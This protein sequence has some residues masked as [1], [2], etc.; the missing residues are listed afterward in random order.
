LRWF[1]PK[2]EV[3]LCGHAMLATAP[4]LWEPGRLPR[5][6]AAFFE[7][8]SGLLTAEPGPHSCQPSR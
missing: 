3:D 4:V 7:T 5:S 6:E 1:T 2:V 8:H